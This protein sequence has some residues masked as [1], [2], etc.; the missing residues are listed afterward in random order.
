MPMQ[1]PRRV[2]ESTSLRAALIFAPFISIWAD[3]LRTLRKEATKQELA[4]RAVIKTG[5]G[6]A[7]EYQYDASGRF[8]YGAKPPWPRWARSFFGDD[9]FGTVV[10]ATVISNDGAERLKA[11]PLLKEVCLNELSITW[12]RAPSE[13]MSPARGRRM[14]VYSTNV[15]DAG[16][17]CLRES[18]TLTKIDL[19]GVRLTDDGLA[20]L[21][22]LTQLVELHFCQTPV[23]DNGLRHLAGLTK[24]K[25]LDL[26]K[27]KTTD[28]GVEV[29]AG[30][31]QLEDVE[32]LGTRITD[33]GVRLLKGLPNLK[34][35]ML[36]STAITDAATR[37]LSRM[38]QLINLDLSDTRVTDIGV[39]R[40][41][42]LSQLETLDLSGTKVTADGLAALAG[43]KR[44]R[45]VWIQRCDISKSE[46]TALKKKL[47][48][49]NIV[50][51]M[52]A[53][54]E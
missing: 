17:R 50:L 11:F 5:G 47:P 40:L 16:V 49:C 38:P 25:T 7:Y 13:P 43:L 8:R 41:K 26:C 37:Y 2:W 30:M 14:L 45:I 1:Q 9:F 52:Y 48:K 54:E 20:N 15:T 34:T 10:G 51:R 53:G 19:C 31:K 24:L 4:V 42:A 33:N 27:T 21:E 35:V 44:L 28:T 23:T 46:L 18:K 22:D 12:S 6:V 3:S 32:L 39:R 36:G 29:I